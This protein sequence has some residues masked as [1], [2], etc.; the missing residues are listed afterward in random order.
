MIPEDNNVI[1]IEDH[2]FSTGDEVV[3]DTDGGAAIGGLVRGQ[4]Y[5]VIVLDAHRIRLAA[6]YCEAVGFAGDADCY[7]EVY[8]H[9]EP[10]LDEDGD[11]VLDED[12]NPIMIPVY[13]DVPIEVA[14]ITLTP[15]K[16]DAATLVSHRLYFPDEL[17]LEGLVDGGMYYVVG[18]DADSFQLA[19]TPGGAPI[20]L[21][22][23]NS[24]GTG[25]FVAG[26][27]DITGT[28]DAVGWLTL[29]LGGTGSGTQVFRPSVRSSRCRPAPGTPR[30]RSTAAVAASSRSAP[31][32]P[33]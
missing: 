14:P 10:L 25:W 29:I 6:S 21:D 33:M 9:D 3:Y 20:A 4:S 12:E 16:T 31:P 5:W 1:Y 19:L 32:T 13:V 26:L 18:A 7:D 28:T 22:G 17:P 23:S 8:S 27:V 15:N 24:P 11:P 30:R 2:P